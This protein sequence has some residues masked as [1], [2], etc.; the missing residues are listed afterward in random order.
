MA[1]TTLSADWLL[2]VEGEPIR[3]GAVVL[4]GDRIAAVGPAA[5]LGRGER[6]EGAA[7]LPGFVDAHSHLEYA[8]YAGFGDGL[9]FGPWLRLH[10]ERKRR[11]GWEET[12]AI[13][14]YGA[15][16]CLRSGITTVADASFSGAAAPAAAELGLRAIVH[17]EVFGA[18]AGQ[19]RERFEPNRDRIAGHLS[20]RVR[21]GVSPHAPY[22]V[23][24]ELFAACLELGL[25]VTTHLAESAAEQEWLSTGGGPWRA[26][27]ESGLL[28]PSPGR[29]AV[30]HLAAEGLLD[31]RVV[32]AHC[33]KVDA[34]EIELLAAHDVA[35]A[36][37]PRSNALLGCG[38]APLR[39]L[40][41][42]GVRV[43]LGTDSPA[44]T[45]SFDAF[46]ELR[47][48]VL[49]ARARDEDAATLSSAG[50]VGLATLGSA[51]AL[52]L[53]AEIGSLL[54]GKRADLTV[55]S[56]EGSH[57]LPW[58]EPE[59]DVV[60]GGAPGRVLLTVVDGIER[61]RKGEEDGWHELSSAAS[62]A[63]SR[64]LGV[65]LPALRSG[66]ARPRP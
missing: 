34:E 62:S 30:R 63:R 3:D 24:P 49:A 20:D 48:A 58:D 22:T 46:D 51:R 6:F 17:L 42:A 38:I 19:L 54:P 55:V 60:Y 41:A 15:A 14:R 9:A 7:I 16:E 36:H 11:I 59:T 50:A 26:L 5:E 37:C 66:G 39:E 21:L 18:D 52:G 12:V 53:E 56:L 64:L 13:A 1:R 2:P 45:P 32:A 25:P 8:V 4:E 65:E 40:R 27:A 31:R 33:V 28:P 10:I 43:G 23:G 44:S 29:S 47:A 57:H 35:V 61:Y